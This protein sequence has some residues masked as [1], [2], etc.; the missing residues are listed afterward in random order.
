MTVYKRITH[1]DV[2]GIKW[3]EYATAN[4]CGVTQ[5]FVNDISGKIVNSWHRTLNELGFDNFEQW[6]NHNAKRP[7][8]L[9]YAPILPSRCS[10]VTL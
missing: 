3:T 10:E 9:R 8:Y 6:E 4:E 5:T 7:D 2:N 1:Y